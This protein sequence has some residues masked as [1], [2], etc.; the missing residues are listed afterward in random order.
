LQ[1]PRYQ[2][3]DEYYS[4]AIE[5]NSLDDIFMQTYDRFNALD[6]VIYEDI[7]EVILPME[8]DESSKEE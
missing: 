8:E 2:Y 1:I 6:D 3:E 5:E 7:D 4:D